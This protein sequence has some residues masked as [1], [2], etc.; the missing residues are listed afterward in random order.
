M[1]NALKQK[2]KEFKDRRFLKKHYC[3]TWEEYNYRHDPDVSYREYVVKHYYRGY[4]Y[5]Y[6]AEREDHYSYKLL[7]DYGP[8]GTRYGFQD[9][10]DWCKL[11]CKGKYRAD[12][13]NSYK[14][15]FFD[16]WQINDIAGQYRMFFA[17]QNQSD[18]V[19]FL[20]KWS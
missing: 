10:A 12:W 19:N 1:Y 9:I 8:G 3:K 18:F 7:Y 2:Y 16:E 5:V 14:N 4:Q 20:M 6:A 11:Q 13:L 15:D 17:F